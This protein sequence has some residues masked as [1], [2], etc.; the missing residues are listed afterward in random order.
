[1]YLGVAISPQVTVPVLP[2]TESKLES[3]EITHSVS[4]LSSSR[5]LIFSSEFL[6]DARRRDREVS[7]AE[8][9]VMQAQTAPLCPCWITEAASQGAGK[10]CGK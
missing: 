10:A 7:T 5:Q 2:P 3:P 6:W 8:R 1:M 9:D 4:F